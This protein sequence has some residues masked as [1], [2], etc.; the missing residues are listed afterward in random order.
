MM[1]GIVSNAVLVLKR[2][3]LVAPPI[4]LAGGSSHV[5]S[6]I[7][8]SLDECALLQET[9]RCMKSAEGVDYR[10]LGAVPSYWYNMASR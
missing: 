4:L 7:A 10:Y 2:F 5:S 3:Q 8:P 1:L 6:R 9:H